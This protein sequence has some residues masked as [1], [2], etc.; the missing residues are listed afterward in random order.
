MDTRGKLTMEINDMAQKFLGRGITQTELRLYP[1]LDYQSKNEQKL[2][3]RRI[4][5]DERAILSTLR[6][7]GHISGGAS[8]LF[9]TKEFY[10]YI[11]NVLWL[12][13]VVD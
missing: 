1:Y 3:P 13:Y 8:G 11:Q 2:D 5:E 6:K 12:G 9:M 10:D 7:E 4:N